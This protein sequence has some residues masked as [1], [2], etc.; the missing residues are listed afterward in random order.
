MAYEA[1]G[2]WFEILNDDCDYPLWSQYFLRGLRSL[3]VGRKGLEL[4]CG[5]GAFSRALT[6]N[7]YTMSAADCSET[8]LAKGSELATREGLSIRFLRLDARRFSSPEKYDFIIA[9]NDLYNYIAPDR[10]RGAF[11]AAASALAKGGVFWFDISTPRKLRGKIA[12][13]IFADDRDD[14]TYLSFNHLYDDRVEM[15][16]TLFVKEK[17]GRFSRYDELHVQYIHTKERILAALG[18]SFEVVRVEGHL[19]ESE[20]GSD[21]W[22]FICRRV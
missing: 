12:D 21:R 15:N 19:G 10:L 1:L 17:D 9:P 5:S 20:E 6:K 3:S 4:G 22:N 14:I 11:R 18:A 16:V 8:M 13:N 2:E 7:G